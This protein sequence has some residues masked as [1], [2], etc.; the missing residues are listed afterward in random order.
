MMLSKGYGLI[1][2]IMLLVMLP[3]SS[4]AGTK[5]LFA[6]LNGYDEVP[7]VFTEANGLFRGRIN[8]DGT[9]DFVLRVKNLSAPI[10]AAHIHFAQKAANGGVVVTLCGG[11]D[12][13]VV[14]ACSNSVRGTIDASTVGGSAAGQGIE[15]GDIDAL[16]AAIRSGNTYVNVHTATFPAGEIRGQIR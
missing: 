7:S 4:Q 16:I 14:G 15:A 11:P 13:A 2:L 12:P 8:R 10:Q 6:F 9:I 3:A 5:S 1:S